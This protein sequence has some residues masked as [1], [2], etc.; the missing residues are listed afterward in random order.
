MK[1]Y[2]PKIKFILQ[3]WKKQECNNNESWKNITENNSII[4][5]EIIENYFEDKNITEHCLIIDEES[6]EL[7]GSTNGKISLSNAPKKGWKNMWYGIYKGIEHLEN[8]YSNNVIV[9]F[10]YDYFEVE[11]RT[12]INE[13]KIIQFIKD[14]LH[15]KNIQ[16][17]KYKQL[18]AD[19]LYMGTYTKIKELTD[20]FHFN[21]DDIL[22][23]I[24]EVYHQ[25]YLVFLIADLYSD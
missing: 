18:G 23:N 22:N 10:R 7:I 14:N 6:I 1:L 11:Y 12:D 19:N 15:K 3:T 8:I 13:V 20:K 24:S 9:S 16:F 21:L 2:F 4:S 25:E 17:I 5:K